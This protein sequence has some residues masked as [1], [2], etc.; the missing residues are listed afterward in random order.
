[1][2]LHHIAIE[3]SD[4]T[5]SVAFYREV[6]G[7]QVEQSITLMGEQLIFL[8]MGEARLEL[9]ETVDRYDRNAPQMHLAFEVDNMF[10][11]I[12]QLNEMKIAII[13]G[14]YHLE[15]GWQSVFVEGP[16]RELIEFIE[17]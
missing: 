3:T 11:L 16:S 2:R 4:L 14:P 15:N 7:F 13:E 12:E 6:I 17:V 9:V 10:Q 1:V 8:K 5:Q